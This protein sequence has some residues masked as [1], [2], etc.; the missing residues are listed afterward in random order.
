MKKDFRIVQDYR[1]EKTIKFIQTHEP[2]EGY[3]LGFSG[4]KDSIVLYDLTQKSGVNFEAHY[5]NTGIDPPEIVKFIKRNY[6]EVVMHKPKRSFY[7]SIP[8]NGFPTKWARWCCDTLKKNPTK[9]VP[10]KHRLLGIRAE[11]SWRRKR[12]PQIEKHFG[13][14]IAYYPILHWL[15]WEVWD[16]IETNNI[17]YPSLYDEGFHRIGCIICPFLCNLN[18]KNLKMH[19]ER[20]PKQYKAFERAMAELYYNRE[21]WRQMKKRYAMTFDEFLNNWY[22][23]NQNIIERRKINK[24]NKGFLKISI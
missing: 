20:W 10:L 17:P 3:F 14:Q 18:S 7:R 1:F 15:E 12:K 8:I 11:E 4:G 19:Q 21:W 2:S 5:S 22:Q 13:K 6:P 24:Y 16:H 23:G 9:D